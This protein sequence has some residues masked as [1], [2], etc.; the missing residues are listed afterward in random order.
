MK[1]RNHILFIK[2]KKIKKT[3]VIDFTVLMAV[4]FL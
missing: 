1:K 2:K 4:S 3:K